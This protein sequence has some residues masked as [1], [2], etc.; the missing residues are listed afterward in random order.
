MCS[1]IRGLTVVLRNAPVF[2]KIFELI[3]AGWEILTKLLRSVA[4]SADSADD[5]APRGAYWTSVMGTEG[6]TEGHTG[7]HGNQC[8]Y[9]L[10]P[11]KPGIKTILRSVQVFLNSWMCGD[12]M[13]IKSAK[14]RTTFFGKYDTDVYINKDTARGKAPNK[15]QVT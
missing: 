15:T 14:K 13:F 8:L 1:Y 12:V 3:I 7:G 6:R 2:K 10:R 11:K 9:S 4:A 5:L